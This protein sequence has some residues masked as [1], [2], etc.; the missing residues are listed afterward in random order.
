MAYSIENRRYIG[1]KAKLSNW[2]MSLI[3]EECDSFSSFADI[4][5][6][7][8][9]IASEASKKFNHIIINDFLH[10]NYF[11]YK[12]FFDN[13]EWNESKLKNIIEKYNKID[14]N[15]L[16]DNFF[17][18]NFGNKYFSLNDSKKIG[19]IRN[20]IEK[21]R[22]KLNEKEYAILLVSL[23]YSIDKISNTVGHYDA[24]FKNSPKDTGVFINM[25]KPNKIKSV[26]IY[27][28]DANLLVR[29]IKADV[30]YIDPPYNSRQYGRFYHLLETLIKWD[31]P[32]LYGV[33]LKPEPENISEYCKVSAPLAFD[34]LI[35]N[36]NAKYIV[37]SY[38]NTYNPKSHSS[39]NKITLEEIEK[40]LCKKGKTKIFKK[41]HKY[42]NSGKTEFNDH[43]EFIF[44][45]KVKK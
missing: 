32:K 6:G 26:E 35:K 5:A 38:N 7:T 33:A 8:G 36:I 9:V 37:V 20:D 17:S 19:Y 22:K 23:L 16:S 31:N 42:F 28:E 40:T 15:N 13:Q 27:R 18:D 39:K 4:F 3:E 21:N 24:Y 45:T 29:H 10:S 25:I 43:Q 12:A 2:I 44:I 30:V 14:A 11:A 1:S 34:D 41:S